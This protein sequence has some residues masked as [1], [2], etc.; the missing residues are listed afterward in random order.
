VGLLSG[1]VVEPLSKN[2]EYIAETRC[3]SCKAF[4]GTNA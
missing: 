4:V 3:P 1:D 2:K